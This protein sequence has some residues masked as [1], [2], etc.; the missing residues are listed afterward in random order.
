MVF[1]SWASRRVR[2]TISSASFF[3]SAIFQVPYVGM[4]FQRRKRRVSIG[5]LRRLLFDGR[6]DGSDVRSRCANGTGD[7]G[8][9][10]ADAADDGGDKLLAGRHLRDGLHTVGVQDRSRPIAPP[11]MTYLSLPLAYSSAA[12]AAATGVFGIGENGHARQKVR[13]A[14]DIRSLKGDLASLFLATRTDPPASRTLARRSCIS[15]T[16]RPW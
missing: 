3:R 6:K 5:C 16:V 7:V 11:R 14:G 1:S 8:S 10:R 4:G 15:A 12:L 13:D 9:R 2:P